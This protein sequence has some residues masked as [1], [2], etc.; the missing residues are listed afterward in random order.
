LQEHIAF[1]LWQ[2]WW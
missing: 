1:E 2:R